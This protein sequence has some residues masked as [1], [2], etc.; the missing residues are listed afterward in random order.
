MA[1]TKFDVAG[2][3]HTEVTTTEARQ[4]T[5]AGMIWVLGISLALAVAAGLALGFGWI[6]LPW[7]A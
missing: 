3:P 7:A 5:H 4:A 2:E 1:T 6:T